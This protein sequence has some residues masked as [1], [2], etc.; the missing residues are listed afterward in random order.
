[1]PYLTALLKKTV[2]KMRKL[3]KALGQALNHREGVALA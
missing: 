1:M 2:S 3:D